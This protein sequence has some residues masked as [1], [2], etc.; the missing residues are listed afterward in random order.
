MLLICWSFSR[1]IGHLL[2]LITKHSPNTHIIHA[3]WLYN[4]IYTFVAQFPSCLENNTG[5]LGPFTHLLEADIAWWN[6]YY[7]TLRCSFDL[8]LTAWFIR[9]LTMGYKESWKETWRKTTY[10]LCYM[11]PLNINKNWWIIASFQA[12]KSPWCL[13]P[14]R[15]G[16][17]SQALVSIHGNL[18]GSPPMPPPPRNKALIRP[19]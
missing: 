12:K 2:F 5:D 11:S 15:K 6:A 16:H 1:E 17:S 8:I 18:R 10:M 13:K 14:Q 3:T 19:N 9:I 4:N 7:S